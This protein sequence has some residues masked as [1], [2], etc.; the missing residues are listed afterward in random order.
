VG[1]GEG[2]RRKNLCS[3]DT[4]PE[5]GGGGGGGRAM[6]PLFLRENFLYTWK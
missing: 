6:S 3:C 1:R 2:K 5:E 4:I